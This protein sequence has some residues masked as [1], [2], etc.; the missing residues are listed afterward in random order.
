PRR[1]AVRAGHGGRPGRPRPGAARP[2]DLGAAE[3]RATPSP[4]P[5]TGARR[6]AANLFGRPRVLPAGPVRRPILSREVLMVADAPRPA[7]A[8]A[9]LAPAG[10]P[11]LAVF[12]WELRRLA[13]GRFSRLL[14][15]AG[16]LF[17]TGLIW[18]KHAWLVSLKDGG[19]RVLVQGSSALGLV[20]EVVYVELLLFG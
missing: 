20:H 17:F 4:P 2:L 8:R 5:L 18:F 19:E 3:G 9:P 12:A 16:F 1:R 11:L 6:A 7:L 14:L 15:L 10:S 13:A